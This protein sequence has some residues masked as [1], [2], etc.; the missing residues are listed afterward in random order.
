VAAGKASSVFEKRERERERERE[1][2]HTLM[3]S[4][5]HLAAVVGGGGVCFSVLNANSNI[6]RGD[7]AKWRRWISK[8][9]LRKRCTFRSL[10]NQCSRLLQCLCKD[11]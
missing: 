5:K 11:F 7:G 4:A 3:R 9:E 1:E 2:K 10:T 6:E 8:D